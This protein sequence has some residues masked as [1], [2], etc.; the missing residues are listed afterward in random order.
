MT[1]LLVLSTN[2]AVLSQENKLDPHDW[3]RIGISGS[4]N[5]GMSLFQNGG[6]MHPSVNLTPLIV[7]SGG[8]LFNKEL[9][10]KYRVEFGLGV[11]PLGFRK[12]IT[13]HYQANKK[14][15]NQ[16]V[17]TSSFSILK[18]PLIG[19][20]YFQNDNKKFYSTFFSAGN[21]LF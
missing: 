14:H 7:P 12:V 11:H 17:E 3:L 6:F 16:N 5:A 8:V 13:T 1:F 15:E 19:Q 18:L 20:Y 21:F 2:G 10:Q 4:I 9:N